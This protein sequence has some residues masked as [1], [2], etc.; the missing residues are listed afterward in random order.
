VDSG[1]CQRHCCGVHVPNHNARPTAT[2]AVEREAGKWDFDGTMEGV[3][4]WYA[5][6]GKMKLV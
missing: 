4:L 3:K 6:T 5:I 1:F 2:A